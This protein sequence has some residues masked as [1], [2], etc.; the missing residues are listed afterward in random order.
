MPILGYGIRSEGGSEVLSSGR[1]TSFRDR[2][3]L[4][5]GWISS[6]T[7]GEFSGGYFVH[8]RYDRVTHCGDF[9]ELFCDDGLVVAVATWEILGR[10]DGKDDESDSDEKD[11]DGFLRR[12]NR[13]IY[14]AAQWGF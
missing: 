14:D 6:E 3:G 13:G 8:G 2:Y 11:R 5:A 10:N 9:C 7:V 4:D 1:H 12:E